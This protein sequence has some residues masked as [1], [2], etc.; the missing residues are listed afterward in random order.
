MN[1]IERSSLI[2][3][4]RFGQGGQGIV[5]PVVNT[6]AGGRWAA[7]YK[8]YRPDVRGRV[9]VTAL[10][11]MVQAAA[12][13]SQDDRI[14][15]GEHTSWPIELVSAGGVVSG[16]IMRAVPREFYFTL[17]TLST[18]D[19]KA[20]LAQIEFL[21]NDDDYVASIGL[22]VSERDRLLLLASL[23]AVLVKLHGLGVSVGDLSP[24]NVLF[25]LT[26]WPHCFL[27]DCD[28]MRVGDR[29][30]LP[31][32]E[33]DDWKVP[34]GE[35]L[36]TAA[37][38][39]HKFA[40]LAAR[41]FARD[42]S[43]RDVF[44]LAA[45]APAVGELAQL[46]LQRGPANRPAL[47]AWIAPL[48]TAARTASE[49]S[50]QPT[51]VI[52]PIPQAPLRPPNG[53]RRLGLVAVGVAAA[54]TLGITWAVSSGSAPLPGGSTMQNGRGVGS[55]DQSPTPP[56]DSS[57]S[58][59]VS[60]TSEEVSQLQ[61]I[62]GILS[63]TSSA[64]SAVVK[65]VNAVGACTQNTTSGISTLQSSVQSRT[66]DA[67]I[68]GQLPVGAIPGGQRL[69]SL[70]V[71]LLQDSAAADKG[72]AQWMH[73]IATQGCPVNTTT[74]SGHLAGDQAST[75]ATQDKRNFVAQWNPLAT[76]FGLTPYTADNL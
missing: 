41:L 38:D 3:G 58:P 53:L 33:T 52:S 69:R 9:N 39:A 47:E 43:S 74:D 27:I 50:A 24:K 2:L 66:S 54:L 42:Q 68:A 60:D 31:Q 61:G 6:M 17:R 49:S 65:A 8:E 76:Q 1:T 36:A 64:R 29:D 11:A 34:D 56:A 35:E 71:S 72:Y 32:V 44:R 19:G 40:L 46:T 16:F 18:T 10:E 15:L 59:S 48:E 26:P 67:Q 20:R 13:L 12:R 73:D 14:W 7:A 37:G 51:A 28:A 55:A 75:S 21:L 30:V 63:D 23:A 22:V 62:A 45:T 25:S 4:E 57:L 5:Y 70:L